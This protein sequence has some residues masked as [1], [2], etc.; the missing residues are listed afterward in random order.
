MKLIINKYFE[1]ESAVS[2]MNIV[3]IGLVVF[4]FFIRNYN[5][6][7]CLTSIYLLNCVRVFDDINSKLISLFFFSYYLIPLPNISTYRGTISYET[8]Q[9]YT[10]MILLGMIPLMINFKKKTPVKQKKIVFNKTFAITVW[11]HI[12]LVYTA[13]LYIAFKY[14]NTLIHQELRFSISPYLVY[15]IKSS[16]YIPL[17]YVFIDSKKRPYFYFLK[18]AALP[19]IPSLIIGSRGTV[20][21]I[22]IAVGLISV[23]KAFKQGENYKLKNS[24]VWDK[25]KKRIY[26]LAGL[27]LVIIHTFYYSRRIFSETLLS[28]MEVVNKYFNSDSP[29]YLPILP[30][31]TSF[32]E[33]IGIA[34]VIITNGL[35]N[36]ISSYPLFIS[37]L[38]TIL[39]GHQQSPGKIIGDI[40]GR[41]LNGGLTPNILGGVYIDFGVWAIFSCSIIV[42]FVKY[43]YSKSYNS[44]TS[45]IL[46]A[47]TLTQ[48]F[49]LFHRGFLKPEYFLAYVILFIYFFLL[50]FDSKILK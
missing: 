16:I 43:L 7:Y 12:A 24:I 23:L 33:T 37:E 29:L 50:S 3:L 48:F 10:L 38:F 5:I 34:N 8:L 31:Y 1:K 18:Y 9:L 30:L 46:Y 2:I 27:I 22:L 28:N 49:H 35:S 4:S 40:I 45:K 17:F 36:N 13:L 47:I 19:L 26:R 44:D 41:K 6:T 21:S 42:V 39:P 14:G 20:I 15:F 32:R 11:I 25:L